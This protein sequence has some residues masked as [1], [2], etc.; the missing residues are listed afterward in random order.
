VPKN[1][2]RNEHFA[3][4]KQAAKS[5]FSAVVFNVI[6]IFDTNQSSHVRLADFLGMKLETAE[7]IRTF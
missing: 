6:L 3:Y 2:T 4:L 7:F 5:N 1:R